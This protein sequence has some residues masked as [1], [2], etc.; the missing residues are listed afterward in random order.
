[1]AKK[2]RKVFYGVWFLLFIAI[3][4]I[5]FTG[6]NPAKI[7]A[8]E[9]EP[10]SVTNIDLPNVTCYTKVTT[11]GLD[12][13]G[14]I[15]LTDDSPFLQKAPRTTFS[16]VGGVDNSDV[17]EFTVT[18]KTRCEVDLNVPMVLKESDLHVYVLGKDSQNRTIEIYN[19]PMKTLDDVP[20]VNNHEEEITEFKIRT[21][22]LM[23]YLENGDYSTL[24][25]FQIAGTLTFGYD[26]NDPIVAGV[27]YEIVVPRDSINSFLELDVTKD[28]EPVNFTP[29]TCAEGEASTPNGSCVPIIDRP[30]I[31]DNQ[32]LDVVEEFTFCAG[33]LDTGCLTQDKF[34]PY[35]I[36]GAGGIILV[37]AMTT[38]NTKAFDAY[39]NYR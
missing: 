6:V 32:V 7:M 17:V 5:I 37:G 38:R 11:N 35:Y 18:P 10:L 8:F 21:V 2:N 31:I 39:G 16:L 13:S 15:V 34:L 36:L 14:T 12:D 20:I 25:T 23:K 22:D 3:T 9:I 1:M 24:L 30:P 26:H 28:I 4:G 33:L 29:T 27:N 19:A